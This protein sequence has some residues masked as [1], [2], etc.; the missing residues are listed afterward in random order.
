M[1]LEK[2]TLIMV[3]PCVIS[4]SV[5]SSDFVSTVCSRPP[6]PFCCGQTVSLHAQ[7]HS[8]I[9]RV[10]SVKIKKLPDT[11]KMSWFSYGQVRVLSLFQLDAVQNL[12]WEL[13]LLPSKRLTSSKADPLP[14]LD[15]FQSI[16]SS[17][18]D[19][20]IIRHWNNWWSK[21]IPIQW[22]FQ[23]NWNLNVW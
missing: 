11:I 16:T 1:N 5:F 18:E 15:Q 20:I 23:C 12:Y 17:F 8:T 10:D 22:I 14:N 9:L 13:N 4:V 7:C 2:L 19:S 3:C 6:F 21:L